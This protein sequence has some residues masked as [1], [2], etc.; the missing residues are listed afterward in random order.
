MAPLMGRAGGESGGKWELETVHGQCSYDSS[1]KFIVWGNRGRWSLSHWF[2]VVHITCTTAYW[3]RRH[4]EHF[5]WLAS[6]NSVLQKQTV[7]CPYVSNYPMWKTPVEFKDL[8]DCYNSSWIESARAS[9]PGMASDKAV[10]ELPILCG[11]AN[12]TL[13]SSL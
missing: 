13:S 2:Q 11:I 8:Y 5:S 3:L 12:S 1:F 9:L 7:I 10:P 4:K 6:L